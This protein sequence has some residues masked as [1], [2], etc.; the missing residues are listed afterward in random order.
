MEWITSGGFDQHLICIVLNLRFLAK[1][2]AFRDQ[3]DN[4]VDLR[5]TRQQY[6]KSSP[7]GKVLGPGRQQVHY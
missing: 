1:N 4:A 6:M 7:E 3:W 2:C 5:Q